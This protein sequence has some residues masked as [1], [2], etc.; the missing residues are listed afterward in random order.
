[1]YSQ[2][3]LPIAALMCAI[4]MSGGASVA[5]SPDPQDLAEWR[6]CIA[7]SGPLYEGG[8][9]G[10]AARVLEKAVKHAEHFAA[11][12]PRL[13]TTIHAL[14]F[15]YQQQSKY[16]EAKR[17]YLRAIDLWERIGPGQH[18][19]LLQSTDNLIGTYMAAHDYSAARK[20]MDS[21]L[22]EMQRPAAKCGDRATLLNWRAFLAYAEHRYDDAEL[23]FRQSLT[24]WEQIVPAEDK[25]A[26]IVLMNLSHVLVATKRYQYALDLKWRALKMLEKLD[27]TARPLVV[28]ELEDVGLLYM[29]LRRPADA[30]PL[31]DRALAMAK[32]TFGPDHVLTCH[33]MLHYSAVLIALNQTKQAKLMTSEARTILRRSHQ[34]QLTVDIHELMLTKR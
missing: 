2:L 10:E 17:L 13:P 9:L 6:K 4:Q 19:A 34:D 32:V 1:M 29:K 15:L 5:G 18:S 7:D 23:L 25:N 3:C 26:A 27:P 14:A 31:Y 33:I 16:A 20:L 12:D 8:H 28:Q 24:L 30:E 11:L 22:P 21:R